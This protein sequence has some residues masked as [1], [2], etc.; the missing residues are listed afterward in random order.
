MPILLSG[1][2]L[3]CRFRRGHEEVPA[4]PLL[5]TTCLLGAALALAG[6][7][8]NSALPQSQQTY[9]S[10]LALIRQGKAR[11]ASE[12]FQQGLKQD[13]SNLLLLNALGGAYTLQ[14]RDKDARQ[15]FL[16]ALKVNPAFTPARKNLALSYFAAG[17]YADA[18]A[19][20]ERLAANP[21]SRFVADLFLGMLAEKEKQ[22]AKAVELMESTGSLLDQQPQGIVALAHS[23]YELRQPDKAQLVLR[24]LNR[25]TN[26][27]PGDYFQAGRLWF[28]QGQYAEA[29]ALFDKANRLAPDLAEL[30]YYRALTLVE[31]GQSG[32]ALDILR[33]STSHHPEA[34]ALN[35]LGHVAQE[36]GDMKLAIQSFY[37]A[38]QLKPEMEENYLDY[39]ALVLD[40]ENY[41]LALEILDAGLAHIPHS[42]RL[43]V[44]KGAVLDKLTR[45]REAEEVFRSA[46]KI[47]DDN[48][49]ALISLAVT[50][51]H[52]HQLSDAAETLSK[53]TERF[54]TDAYMRYYYGLVL[55]QLAERQD[56]KPEVAEAAR[57]EIEKATKLNPTYAD[58]YYQL[59]KTYLQT[60][61]AKAAEELE[62]CLRLQPDHYSAEMQLGRLYQRMD[63]QAEGDRLL[64]KAIRDKQAEKEKEERIPHMEKANPSLATPHKE[65]LP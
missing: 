42:Y 64:N 25:L 43:L 20:F 14:G 32:Q 6:E 53:A 37:R 30:D 33:R 49:V 48:R 56:M 7:Q 63:R 18:K 27:S 58:A 9:E 60:D 40:S 19:E 36:T 31:L 51:A 3:W 50:Q 5:L 55:V 46:I 16:A 10:G 35:L 29:L 47:Q 26:V 12:L 2:P 21:E 15:C 28:R 22:F 1:L 57:R 23:Y 62:A 13:P 54:P 41:P 39:S 38:C 17:E 45:R 44:Q 52:D 8:G 34:R 4:L 65:E 59:A 61:P 24:R 11:E